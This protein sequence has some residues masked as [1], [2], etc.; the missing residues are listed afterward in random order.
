[1]SVRSHTFCTAWQG[2]KKIHKSFQF[3]SISC[4]IFSDYTFADNQRNIWY[5]MVKITTITIYS[6]V[7]NCAISISLH[8]SDTHLLGQISHSVSPCL[9]CTKGMTIPPP[10]RLFFVIS[11]KG[12]FSVCFGFFFLWTL[13][14]EKNEKVSISSAVSKSNVGCIRRYFANNHVQTLHIDCTYCNDFSRSENIL[15]TYKC[16]DEVIFDVLRYEK[17]YRHTCAEQQ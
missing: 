13:C 7:E 17:Y 9:R 3:D 12:F 10:A 11:L 15:N 14:Q 8:E 2:G 16:P 6:W 4:N 1:M 5:T